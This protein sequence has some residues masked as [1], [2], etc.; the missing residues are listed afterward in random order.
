MILYNYILTSLL[1]NINPLRTYDVVVSVLMML[2]MM[3]SRMVKPKEE[4]NVYEL[5]YGTHMHNCLFPIQLFYDDLSL[6]KFNNMYFLLTI[7]RLFS[8]C[9]PQQFQLYRSYA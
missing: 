6:V 9:C 4:N 3:F 5:L 1:A 2:N 7:P 8:K